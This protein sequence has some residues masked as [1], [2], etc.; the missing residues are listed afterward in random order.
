MSGGSRNMLIMEIHIEIFRMTH[1]IRDFLYFRFIVVSAYEFGYGKRLSSGD[2]CCRLRQSNLLSS[3]TRDLYTSWIGFFLLMKETSRSQSLQC[4][5]SQSQ[6]FSS[7]AT[8]WK[9]K[10]SQ[11]D[12]FVYCCRSIDICCGNLLWTTIDSLENWIKCF[13][14]QVMAGDIRAPDYCIESLA[15]SAPDDAIR[16]QIDKAATTD[17]R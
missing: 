10:K 16:S 4:Q 1:S 5:S 3:Q 8:R 11:N 12:V 13:G 7:V 14:F 9:S 2:I 15:P 17:S 6:L